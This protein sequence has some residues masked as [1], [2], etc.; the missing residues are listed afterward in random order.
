MTAAAPR[1]QGGMGHT[2]L[3]APRLNPAVP[4]IDPAVLAAYL[5]KYLPDLS[6]AVGALYTMDP[7]IR[8][9]HTAMP[10]VI[11]QALTVKTPPGDNL[12]VHAAL[13]M[14]QDGDVLV[15]D[16]RGHTGACGSGAGS[17]V[18][19]QRNGL[20]GIITDGSWR[21]VAELG[22]LGLGVY[23]RTVS[24]FSPAKRV[25]GEINVPVTCGGVI[26]MPGDLVV[27]DAEG[28]VVIPQAAAQALA[29]LVPD[30]RPRRSDEWPVQDITGPRADRIAG[31]LEQILDQ[32]P[33][34]AVTD[35]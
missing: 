7:A 35:F 28:A 15:I 3:L 34:N 11:G 20:R 5:G 26:V 31:Y 32:V 33:A 9:L 25:L 8:P 13:R 10:R 18:V 12:T 27:A 2:P 19:P 30:Y 6:D 16:S 14:V 17:L 23:G 29:E 1:V 21:D 4:R 22:N 24:P